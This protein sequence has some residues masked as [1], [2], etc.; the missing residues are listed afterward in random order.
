MAVRI[1]TISNEIG[2]PKGLERR[3]HKPKRDES[4][5]SSKIL[6]LEWEALGRKLNKHPGNELEKLRRQ[7]KEKDEMLRRANQRI[8]ALTRQLGPQRE[9]PRAQSPKHPGY[10]RFKAPEKTRK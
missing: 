6:E 3:S 8:A 10:N 2:G 7:L 1:K 9:K 4:R 5:Q